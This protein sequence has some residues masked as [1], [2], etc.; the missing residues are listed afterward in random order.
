MNQRV[1]I[2]L[3]TLGSVHQILRSINKMFERF[4]ICVVY[5][6]IYGEYLHESNLVHAI[7][8]PTKK[9]GQCY[10]ETMLMTISMSVAFQKF[11]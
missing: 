10:L 9:F 8:K 11:L 5:D 1:V 7:S 3:T 6:V 4:E 2:S